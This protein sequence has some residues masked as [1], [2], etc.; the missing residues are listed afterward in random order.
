[1]TYKTILIDDEPLALQRLERLLAPFRFIEI[2]AKAASGFEAVE[3]IN[4]LK[5]DLIFLDIQMP[6]LTG[7]EVLEQIDESP[8][9]IFP[10][11]MMNMF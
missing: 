8:F 6:E 2:T 7:F 9:I 10:L 11:L 3:K 1:M 4:Q 5:P